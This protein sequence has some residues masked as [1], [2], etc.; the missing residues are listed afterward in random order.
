MMNQARKKHPS[1][2]YFVMDAQSLGFPN[3]NFDYVIAN[4]ILS[5]VPDPV[6]CFEEIVRV[7]RE[8]GEIWIFDKFSAPDNK[9]L[10]IQKGVSIITS[11]F[12]TDISVNFEKLMSES[13]HNL[14]VYEDVPVWLK[15][16]Y[17]VIKIKKCL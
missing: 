15:G 8:G 16:K 10:T 17:R 7:T 1:Y 6:K 3:Q 9:Y 12:G 14:Y 4:L 5:V 11:L 2:N 13:A